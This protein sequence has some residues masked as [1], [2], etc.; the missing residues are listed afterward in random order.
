MQFLSVLEREKRGENLIPHLSSNIRKIVPDTRAQSALVS[1]IAILLILK[2]RG[3]QIIPHLK[4]KTCNA[5]AHTSRHLT[6]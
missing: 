3:E 6:T 1:G 5:D 2:L 4:V